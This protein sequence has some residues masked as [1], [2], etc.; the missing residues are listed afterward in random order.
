MPKKI[1]LVSKIFLDT[2]PLR[3]AHAGRGIGSYTRHL[4]AALLQDKSLEMLEQATEAELIHY[5]FFD[6]FAPT[7]PL[8][9]RK[10]IVVTI[11]DVI[12]LLFSKFYPLGKRARV[13]LVRQRLALRQVARVITD[14]EASKTD[15]AK[16]LKVKLDKISVVPLAANPELRAAS[17][18]EQQRVKRK[19]KLPA[20]YLLYVGDINYNK[21]LPQLIKA[22]KYLPPK[23][24]LVLLGQNFRQQD[25][26]EWQWIE[27]QVA[28]SDVGQRVKFLTEVPSQATDD[29]SAIYSGAL[30]YVQPSLYEGFGLPVLEAMQCQTPVICHN[31]SSLAEVALNK[32]MIA[33]E[34][35]AE[36]FAQQVEQI[37]GWSV[38]MRQQFLTKAAKWANTFTWRKTARLTAVVYQ[39]VL[40]HSLT[41]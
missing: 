31:N 30:A 20:T 1:N 32:A 41:K 9:S 24:K 29:L 39:Q 18:S 40:G 37:M 17:A 21:N 16:Y 12:P 35:T 4:Q 11:H 36:A 5:P 13:N 6:L 25:I 22:L 15:I 33:A 34:P 3:N 28:L 2:S 38:A 19:Y 14:S 8:L 7:L 23:V 10:P 27:S 26:P